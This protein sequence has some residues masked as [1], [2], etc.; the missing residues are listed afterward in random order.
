L[1]SLIKY[2]EGHDNTLLV[3]RV[4]REAMFA[5]DHANVEGLMPKEVDKTGEKLSAPY[6]WIPALAIRFPSFSDQL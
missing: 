2:E 6:D 4:D 1:N 5:I 3:V